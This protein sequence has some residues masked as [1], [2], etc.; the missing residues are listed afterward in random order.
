MESADALSIGFSSARPR[1]SAVDVEPALLHKYKVVLVGGASVGKSSI[2]QRLM[3]NEFH[4]QD[5]AATGANARGAVNIGVKS[6]EL[7]GLPRIVVE[8][9]DVPST[10]TKDKT[11]QQMYLEHADGIVFVQS[12]TDPASLDHCGGYYEAFMQLDGSSGTLAAPSILLRNK[13]DKSSKHKASDVAW[14]DSSNQFDVSA[15]LNVGLLPALRFLVQ[16]MT[17]PC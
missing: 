2:F 5:D 14:L 7:D 15:K 6:V 3:R 10:S 16:S 1:K 8:L 17:K 12:A 4:E 9:W 13:C 11:N